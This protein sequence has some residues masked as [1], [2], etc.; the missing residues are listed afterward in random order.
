MYSNGQWLG[1]LIDCRCLML[2]YNGDV[3]REHALKP[4]L[5]G[6]KLVRETAAGTDYQYYPLGRHVVV[7]P[8]VCGGRPTFK[9]TRI[10]VETILDWLRAGRT[11]EDIIQGYPRWSR[12]AIREA[13]RIATRTLRSHFALKAA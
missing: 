13:I 9:G 2:L 11:V 5:K 1:P 3:R 7:A 4:T 6:R 12:A 10:E 8:G